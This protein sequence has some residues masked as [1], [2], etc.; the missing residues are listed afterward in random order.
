MQHHIKMNLMLL[1]TPQTGS[2][3]E[4]LDLYSIAMNYMV[5]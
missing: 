5:T 2:R 1:V 4:I 3:K